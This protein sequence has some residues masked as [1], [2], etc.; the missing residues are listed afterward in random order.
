MLDR[1]VGRPSFKQG[2][3][4]E[5]EEQPMLRRSQSEPYNKKLCI[6]CQIENKN[7][8]HCVQT[9]QI[10]YKIGCPSFAFEFV[11]LEE[12]IKEVNKLS[13]KKASQT[14]DI[15][16]KIVKENK[17]LISYFVYNNFNNALS[18]LQ[19][20]NGLKYA[21]VTPVF[22][23]D[24]KSDKS[25]YRPISILSNLSKVYERIMQKQIYPYLNKIFSKYQC[26]FRKGF[27]AQHC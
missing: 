1:K 3:Q 7:I 5:Y 10:G 17:D 18:S 21:D 27:S 20:P 22:K 16:V 26:G 15:P 6:I 8:L 25:N 19:Y 4:L 24:D 13:I 12:T 2:N 14:L 9:L 11:T 23:K